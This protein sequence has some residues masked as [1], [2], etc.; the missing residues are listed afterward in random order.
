MN[1]N[2]FF[3]RLI[4]FT[5]NPFF[6]ILLSLLLFITYRIYFEPTLLC[7]G[8]DITLAENSNNNNEIQ[9]PFHKRVE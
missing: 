4:L 2:Y 8:K 5:Y 6:P 9:H 3:T 7:D 1:N